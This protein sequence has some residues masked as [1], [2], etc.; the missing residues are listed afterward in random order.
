MPG[1]LTRQ[2]PS[3]HACCCWGCCGAPLPRKHAVGPLSHCEVCLDAAAC[4]GQ[5]RQPGAHAAGLSRTAPLDQ[6]SCWSW[7]PLLPPPPEAPNNPT[8]PRPPIRSSHPQINPS[9]FCRYTDKCGLGYAWRDRP[10][11]HF[12]ITGPATALDVMNRLSQAAHHEAARTYLLG[13]V[14]DHALFAAGIMDKD[15]WEGG[16]I[17]RQAR[18]WAE[19]HPMPREQLEKFKWD[20]KAAGKGAMPPVLEIDPDPTAGLTTQDMVRALG[21]QGVLEDSGGLGGGGRG[22]LRNARG[23]GRGYGGRGLGSGGGA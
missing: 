12:T 9:D 18:R 10:V 6:R 17:S 16:L 11:A 13:A 15:D 4:G 19:S 14:F 23:A 1:R 20:R 5:V 22:V 2:V 7:S 21:G 8:P 3:Q